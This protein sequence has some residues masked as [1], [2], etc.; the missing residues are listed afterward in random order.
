MRSSQSFMAHGG[1]PAVLLIGLLLQVARA[2]EPGPSGAAGSGLPQF[3]YVGAVLDYEGLK[4]RPHADVIFPSVIR[5]DRRFPK[6][7]ARY[8]MYY[9]PH[10]PP[11]GIC[12]AHAEGLE[13]PWKEYEA[14]P[15]IRNQWPP[16]YNV[17]HVCGPDAIWNDEE[18]KLF[19][20]FH[21]ENNTTRFATS[22][23]GIHFTYG[24][25]AVTTAMISGGGGEASYARVFR[26]AIP[27]KTNRYVMTFMG[28]TKGAPGSGA[29]GGVNRRTYLA[30][31]KDGWQWEARKEPFI[32]PP[33]GCDQVGSSWYFP[34]K[35]RHYFISNGC[36]TGVYDQGQPVH[37]LYV[38]EVDF[39]FTQVK[40]LGLYFDRLSMPS[41]DNGGIDSPCI[42]AEGGK[43]YMFAGVGRRLNNK[44]GLAVA[45][46]SP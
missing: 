2:A 6:P 43:L 21:G 45:A 39:T 17:S 22:D 7:L 9:S 28:H 15:L 14:N 12:L 40:D 8:Y 26:Y 36:P 34:W 31:S 32:N 38:A 37:N 25:I 4:Y 33:A 42:V 16:H 10:D 44:I 30:W 27:G 29:F 3:R 41:P 11:G 20:Y 35:S 18:S 1:I 24:G 23:D 5:G 19:L 46:P 13:G